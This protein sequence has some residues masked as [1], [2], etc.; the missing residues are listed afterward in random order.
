[1]TN[2]KEETPENQ[3]ELE[4]SAKTVKK[5]GLVLFGLIIATLIW[6][7]MSDRYA[8]YTTQARV[9]GYVVGVSP[10]V[11]GLITNVLVKNNQEVEAEQLL[12]EIDSSQ[13]QIALDKALSD[14]ENAKSQVSAGDA[15]VSS[16]KANLL[17][18]KASQV[19]AQQDLDRLSRLH[20]EDPGTISVRRIEISQASLEQAK[21]SVIAA[22]SEINRA[23]E[24]KGGNDQDNNAIIKSA[25]SAVAKAQL[26]LNNT[27]V[28]AST[29]GVITDLRADIGQYANPGN[30][31]M[32]LVAMHDVWINAEFTENN[33]GHLKVGSAVD[34]LF[35][36]VPGEVFSG[37]IRSIGIG[38]STGRT[39]PAGTLPSIDNNR[40]WLR[41]SQRFPVIISF[42]PKQEDILRKQLRIGAQASVVAYAQQEGI[43]STLGRWYIRLMSYL[44]YAY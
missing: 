30:P 13:F 41:Q 23:I 11:G 28:K 4:S 40:D 14:L 43:I 19:K 18:A 7:L 34:I 3:Q 25:Q 10:K 27:Q 36:A 33:L 15:G 20:Q 35:D 22:T 16:A 31:V 42:N 9:Q 2:K 32:T 1:M 21:A 37:K 12:F 26:D 24:Q 29:R 6:Y 38:V 39:Q 17:A 5:G 44:S 8:P